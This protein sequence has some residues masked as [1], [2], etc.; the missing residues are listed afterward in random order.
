MRTEKDFEEFLEL[1]TKHDVR[2]CIVGSY[3]LA[4]YARPR[5]TKDMD[6]WVEFTPGN[7]ER[8]N[9]ALADFGS[10]NLLSLDRDDE[11]L[12]LGIAPDRIDF[13]L[14]MQGMDFGEAWDRRIRGEYGGVTANWIDLDSL[15]KIKSSIDKPRHREDARILLEIKK[16]GENPEN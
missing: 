2:Y 14:R 7:L 15:L 9:K 13:F 4:F 3:A 8:A 5:Y 1:L 10:P 12:Q 16:M 6:I 11:V